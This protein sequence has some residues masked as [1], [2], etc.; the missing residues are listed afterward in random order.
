MQPEN[1]DANPGGEAHSTDFEEA[2]TARLRT[3]GSDRYA[4]QTEREVRRSWQW[5][6]RER[7]VDELAGVE[8]LDCRRWV[9]YGLGDRVEDGEISARTAHTY[10]DTVRATWEWWVR[11]GTI[12]EN[13]MARH[14]V[15]EELPDPRADDDPDQQV[16]PAESRQ[17]LLRHMDKQVD[18]ALEGGEDAPSRAKAFRDRAL[19]YLLADTGARGAELCAVPGD[20][21]RNGLRWKD[22]DLDGRTI[23]VFGKSRELEPIGLPRPTA[24]KLSVYQRWLDPDPEDP[25]LPTL[26][27]TKRGGDGPVPAL[28]TNGARSRLRDISKAADAYDEDG[29]P[30][31][32]HGARRLL[33]HEMYHQVSAE[34]SQSVMRHRSIETTKQAY[35][36][37]EAA[38]VAEDVEAVRYG[39]D[40]EP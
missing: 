33:G 39:D 21:D 26:D 23:Q 34:K 36:H 1:T 40:S 2:L 38:E 27:P 37:A 14:S 9:Q 15:T 20:K 28:T 29:E 19:V 31:K 30:L 10:F 4:D 18:A 6:K 11:D 24:Q 16:W 17:R 25:V 5:L 12:D 13:P 7:G 35:E 32:P 22:V 3:L 8:P